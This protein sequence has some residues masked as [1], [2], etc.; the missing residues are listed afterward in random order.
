MSLP[1]SDTYLPKTIDGQVDKD[2]TRQYEDIAKGSYK[3]EKKEEEKRKEKVSSPLQ[4]VS[5]RRTKPAAL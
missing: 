4:H 1:G 5:H 2:K 3:K